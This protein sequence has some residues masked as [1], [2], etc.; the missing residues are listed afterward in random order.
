MI[1]EEFDVLIQ[2]L[3]GVARRHPR[4]Y[5]ARIVGLVALA[6]GY[7]A[8]IL[9]KGETELADKGSHASCGCGGVLP[10]SSGLDEHPPL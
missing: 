6:Y 7:L 2:R 1:R 9:P 5:L 3:E 4:L 10:A 8:L